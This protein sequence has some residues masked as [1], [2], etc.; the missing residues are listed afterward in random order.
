MQ[1]SIKG[2]FFII[3]VTHQNKWWRRRW[4]K[5]PSKRGFS[6]VQFRIRR[7]RRKKHLR[8]IYT[9]LASTK[10]KYIHKFQLEEDPVCTTVS[11]VFN[12]HDFRHFLAGIC[13]Y[14][15]L[16]RGQPCTNKSSALLFSS[17]DEFETGLLVVCLMTS[18]EQGRLIVVLYKR[19]IMVRAWSKNGGKLF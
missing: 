1:L 6:I 11:F 2:L 3:Y 13:E 4:K 9:G 18:L 12:S 15:N 8:L 5:E 10:G 14:F 17:Y 7:G 16:G 19:R